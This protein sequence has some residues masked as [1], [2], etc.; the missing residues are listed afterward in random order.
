M[1]AKAA[2]SRSSVHRVRQEDDLLAIDIRVGMTP[3]LRY[4]ESIIVGF[5]I[6]NHHSTGS[7]F[8]AVQISHNPQRWVGTQN[9]NPEIANSE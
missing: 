6:Q 4:Q 8:Q 5:P 7:V 2:E 9:R 1:L 3:Y